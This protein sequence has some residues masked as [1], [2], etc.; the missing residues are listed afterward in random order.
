M[1]GIRGRGSDGKDSP[2]IRSRLCS[3]VLRV[4]SAAAELQ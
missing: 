1:L 4:N 3:L 2:D